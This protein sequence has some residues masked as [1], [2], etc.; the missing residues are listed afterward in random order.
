MEIAS[1]PNMQENRRVA[2]LANKQQCNT[3]WIGLERQED[4]KNN[5]KKDQK[6]RKP[7][8][9]KTWSDGSLTKFQAWAKGEPND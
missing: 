5:S 3:V 8:F 1:I 7:A 9:A 2:N 4:S 6:A